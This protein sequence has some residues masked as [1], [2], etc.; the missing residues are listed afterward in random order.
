MQTVTMERRL[1]AIFSADVQGYSRLMSHDEEETIH[2]LTAYRN[3]M[4]C[5][6]QQY[7]GRVVDSAGD[8]ILAEF[9]SV[10]DAMQCAVAVQRTLSAR[11]RALPAHRAMVFRVGINLGDVVVNEERI[12]GDGVNIAAR[13]ESL[14]D[15][16]GIC[17][18]GT[19]YDQVESKLDLEYVYM[20]EQ[21]VKNIAK[22]VR[23]YRVRMQPETTTLVVRA[24]TSTGRQQWL[25]TAPVALALLIMLAAIAA[26]WCGTL[27]FTPHAAAV[28]LARQRE[29]LLPHIPALAVLPFATLSR[30]SAQ[31]SLSKGI[32]EELI[33]EL[34]RRVGIFVIDHQA[35]VS[36]T[37]EPV[38]VQQIGQQLGV[39]YV[40]TG[41]V[42][43]MNNRVRITTRLVDATTGQYL[44]ANRYDGELHDS[45]AL[46]DEVTQRIVA[47]LHSSV[48]Q[49]LPR[50]NK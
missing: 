16:G 36:T 43:K 14:A 10:V 21:V 33:T 47:A 50:G 45:F 46:Q 13:L 39:Q 22:P 19:V 11:N 24:R 35:M 42:R 8:N 48:F 32:T 34:S 25:K 26:L 20:G 30:G 37:G 5:L 28:A 29:G 38:Q 12:Y 40:L 23:V 15:G 41:S 31:E 2:T 7:R 6:I 9:A 18:A 4:T 3:V 27:R 17:I 44:W 49:A 1:A